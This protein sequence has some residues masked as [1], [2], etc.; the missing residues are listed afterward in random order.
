MLFLTRRRGEVVIIGDAIQ[1]TVMQFDLH[2]VRLGIQAPGDLEIHWQ[3]NARD[4]RTRAQ[5][6]SPVSVDRRH[7]E[8]VTIGGSIQI[9][10]LQ[11]GLH[12]IRLRVE[13]PRD[14]RVDRDEVHHRPQ[15][16]HASEAAPPPAPAPAPAPAKRTLR[17][18]SLKRH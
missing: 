6:Q 2:Q 9:A 4:I 14:V 15:V 16:K 12:Q 10:I 3:E 5:P 13:A 7:T 18:L 11:T 1:V 17:T 8:T